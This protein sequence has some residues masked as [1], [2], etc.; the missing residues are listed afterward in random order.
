MNGSSE[1]WASTSA[2]PPTSDITLA[3]V[4]Y[5]ADFVRFT[6]SNR[7]SRWGRGMTAVVESPGGISPPGAPR[8]VRESLD[9]HGSRCSTVDM[10]RAHAKRLCLVPGLLP[11]PVGPE[12]R[13]NNAATSVKLHYRTFIPTKNC[14]APVLRIGTPVLADLAACD[15]SLNIGT[16]GS[17]VPYKSPVELRAAYT[18]DAARAVFR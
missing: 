2:Y 14:S 9:S 6:P 10:H 18:P 13:Q 16:T 1:G 3:D 17:H 4:R 8:T 12:P 15:L 11:L 5:R 7:R